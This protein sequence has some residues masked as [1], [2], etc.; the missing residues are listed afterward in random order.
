[1]ISVA[2]DQEQW[3]HIS[4]VR[5]GPHISHLAFVDDVLL[6]EEASEG[7]LL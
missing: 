5:G 1:M 7:V 6:Y 4:L 2:I 3:K